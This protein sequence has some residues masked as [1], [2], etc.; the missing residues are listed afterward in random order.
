LQT[1]SVQC[2]NWVHIW[3]RLP[4]NRRQT[5][6]ECLYF[7]IHARTTFLPLVDLTLT[8]F[9]SIYEF[10]VD[11]LKMYLHTKNTVFRSRLSKVRA[12]TGQ[13]HTQSDYQP[14]SRS[15]CH[16][17]HTWVP[18]R[19]SFTTLRTIPSHSQIEHSGALRDNNSDDANRCEERR[20]SAC[21]R[22][23]ASVYR[24]DCRDNA[25]RACQGRANTAMIASG[26]LRRRL[27][28]IHARQFGHDLALACCCITGNRSCVACRSL[29]TLACWQHAAREYRHN[30]HDNN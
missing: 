27:H 26:C 16:Q 22:G 25:V 7:I 18:S 10:D 14:Y 2:C 12:R 1:V 30:Y 8:R 11:T 19:L 29:P 28:A 21:R 23:G 24:V 4:F 20:L 3:T 6:R 15:P 5:T 13:R 17:L 9:I